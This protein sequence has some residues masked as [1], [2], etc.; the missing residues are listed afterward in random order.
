MA[1]TSLEII[2]D[3]CGV[4]DEQSLDR[5]N[6]LRFR[7]DPRV[8][9]RGTGEEVELVDIVRDDFAIQDGC[10]PSVPLLARQPRQPSDRITVQLD[11]DDRNLPPRLASA[12]RDPLGGNPA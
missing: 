2:S 11:A 3:D 6:V 8:G 5:A 4:L 9:G 1:R 7:I 10:N 12:A